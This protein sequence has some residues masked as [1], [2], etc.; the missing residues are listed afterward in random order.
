MEQNSKTV[1]KINSAHIK[2]EKLQISGNLFCDYDVHVRSPKVSVIFECEGE[3]RILPLL[4]KAYYPLEDLKTCSIIVKYTYHIQDIFRFFK[5]G[6]EIKTT[7]NLD[8]GDDFN[9]SIECDFDID[10]DLS[11]GIYTMKYEHDGFI[12]QKKEEYIPKRVPSRR[13][14][15]FKVIVS[16]IYNFLLQLF[17]LLFIPILIIDAFMAKMS[18]TKHSKRIKSTGIRF[19]IDH[20]RLRLS[21]LA[22]QDIGRKKFKRNIA[23]FFTQIYSHSKVVPN[24]ITFLSNRR[25]DLTGNFQYI[26][27]VLKED[28]TLDIQ[29]LLD[30]TP[31]HRMKNKNIKKFAKLFATSSVVLIDDFYEYISFIPKKEEVKLVQVWHACG[32]FKTFGFSRLGK[33]GG[34][35]QSTMNHRDYDYAIVSSDNI[36][37]YYAEGFGISPEKVIT[38]G[39]PRTDMFFD[40]KNKEQIKKEFYEAYPK[41]KDKKIM[42]FAPTFR[43]NGKMSGN[44]PVKKFDLKKIYEETNG[45]YAILVKLHPFIKDTFEI[46][47]EYKDYII[48]F[49]QRSELNDLLFVTDVLVSDYSSAIFEASLLNVPMIFYA[50]DLD[51]YISTRDFYCEY[52]LLLPGK[53]TNNI[54]EFVEAVNNEDFETEKIAPFRDR[55]FEQQDGKSSHRVAEFVESLVNKD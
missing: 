36:R 48:D 38:T 1:L 12:F 39:V 19:Y 28:K 4:I 42:L 15:L 55:F 6:K 47:E 21:A 52:K 13:L 3:K 22:K 5:N 34:P 50:F 2:D 46:P 30:P 8:Y 29:F 7:F 9:E 25:D 16:D 11:D 17:S 53:L 49:S 40:E 45:E 51:E 35:K 43:G 54:S 32:A 24:R 26:Y 44:Y 14:I 23:L 41:L 33:P 10:T 18:L 20:I 37:R 31:M 27:D